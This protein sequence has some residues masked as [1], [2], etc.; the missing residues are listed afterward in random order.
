MSKD[1]HN[2]QV[3]IVEYMTWKRIEHFA[4]PNGVFFNAESK[5][6]SAAYMS[7]LKKEGFR[8]GVSDLVILLPKRVV[9]A[10]VKTEKGKQNENQKEY[11]RTVEKLG[12]E[13]LLWRSLDDCIK[14][15]NNQGGNNDNGNRILQRREDRNTILNP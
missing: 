14:W 7:R 8:A 9:F 10:E 6:K 1:E 3:A 15:L 5:N 13:Y 11:Q 12:F 4:V 2:I